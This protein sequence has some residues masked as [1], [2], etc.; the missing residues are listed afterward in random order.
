MTVKEA[1]ELFAK[2][3]KIIPL[4]KSTGA[5]FGAIFPR[6]F[7]ELVNLKKLSPEDSAVKTK[8][9]DYV[10]VPHTLSFVQ[11]EKLIERNEAI[12]VE[13]RDA[14]NKIVK[15]QVASIY[16]TMKFVC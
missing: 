12:L 4:Q 6:K 11:L 16:D 14:E 10:V 7:I 5:Y 9:N 1:K 3:A 2:G 8:T 13:T 15:L